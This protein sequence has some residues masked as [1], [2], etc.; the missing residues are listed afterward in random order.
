MSTQTPLGPCGNASKSVIE[1]AQVL[2]AP[3]S[4]NLAELFE[5]AAALD[6]DSYREG[7]NDLKCS[8]PWDSDSEEEGAKATECKAPSQCAEPHVHKVDHI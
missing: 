2:L 5:A 7:A 3:K 8:Q 4:F 1:N 6:C